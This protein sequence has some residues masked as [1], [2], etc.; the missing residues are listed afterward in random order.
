M[1][2]SDTQNGDNLKEK[3]KDETEQS[4]KKK[5]PV[6]KAKTRIEKLEEIR[7]LHRDE[8]DNLKRELEAKEKETKENHDKWLRLNAEFDNFKKRMQREKSDFFKYA[9]ENILRD[10]LPLMDDLER[11]VKAVKKNQK[12]E[13]FIIGIEMIMNKIKN[14][15][16]SNWVKQVNCVGQPFDPNKHEAVSKVSTTEHENNTIIEELRKGYMYHDRLLR[17]AMVIVAENISGK[18]KKKEIEMKAETD[19]KKGTG[20]EGEIANKDINAK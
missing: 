4:E 9:G 14:S 2:V 18:E 5:A 10:F 12:V 16:A 6:K 19:K 1:K 15:L 8:V 17:P 3:N 20:G 13:D 7:R 11:A